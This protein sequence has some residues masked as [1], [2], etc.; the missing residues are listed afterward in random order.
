M[1]KKLYFHFFRTSSITILVCAG[2]R[3]GKWSYK[4]LVSNHGYSKFG[5]IED[6]KKR[7]P[8]LIKI[9][10]P[11]GSTSGEW[12]GD[13]SKWW[14]EKN[15]PDLIN[16]LKTNKGEFYLPYED[17]MQRFCDLHL[18]YILESDFSEKQ[19]FGLWK[20]EQKKILIG[21]HL[22]EP[23]ETFISLSQV[24][25]R[26]LRDELDSQY[27]MLN[28]GMI[29]SCENRRNILTQEFLKTREGSYNALNYSPGL[30]Y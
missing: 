13:W 17:F 30:S 11:W 1:I 12:I 24:G 6:K 29:I 2:T 20:N 3:R 19:I 18:C 16:L 14:I 15:R 27:T 8:K 7:I 10:N 4:G 23:A 22:D 5:A 28:I 21:F 25:R 9:R 26:Q